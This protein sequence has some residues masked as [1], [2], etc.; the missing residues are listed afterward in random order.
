MLTQTPFLVVPLRF[1]KTTLLSHDDVLSPTPFDSTSFVAEQLGDPHA[2]SLIRHLDSSILSL[3]RRLIQQSKHF[4][5]QNGALEK[6]IPPRE[7]GY[8]CSFLVTCRGKYC[9]L[10]MMILQLAI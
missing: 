5:L 2:C 8:F 1:R 4:V 7:V 3:D 10:Y 6:T 9:H